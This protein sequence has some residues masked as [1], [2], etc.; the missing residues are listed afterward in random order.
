MR[1]RVLWSILAGALVTAALLFP[2]VLFELPDWAGRLLTIL[3]LGLAAAFAVLASRA[4]VKPLLGD[5]NVPELAP[6]YKRLASQDQLIA[7]QSDELQRQQDRFY[8]VADN[9]SEGFVLLDGSGALLS[10]NASAKR[11][12]D[13]VSDSPLGLLRESAQAALQGHHSE[14]SVVLDGHVYQILASPVGSKGQTAGAVL[15]ALDVTEK[16]QRETMRHD[17]SSNVSHELKTPLTSIYGISELILNGLVKP[18]DIPQFAK[19]IHDESGRLITLISDIM[20]LSQLDD[21]VPM[22][23]V[24]CDLRAIAEDVAERLRPAA[25]ERGIQIRLVG[26]ELVVTG[27]PSILDEM[28]YNLCDNAVKYNVENG[29]VDIRVERR[30]GHPEVSVSDTG[31]GIPREHQDRV[32]ERFYRVDKSHSREIGGT[33]L[34]LSIVKHGAACHDAAVSLK[35]AV[36][37]GTT[38]TI[39]FKE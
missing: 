24:P 6:L 27:I 26:E 35:S 23:R 16:V 10:C 8:A 5:G 37:R 30:N 21:S 18:E 38:V 11:L 7:R 13:A 19:T 22:E 36:G 31:I 14:R 39:T 34:G 17:F 25:A 9:M 1:K 4:A 2:A 20:R 12:V 33:G 28:V 3:A 32:F 15:V 29:S